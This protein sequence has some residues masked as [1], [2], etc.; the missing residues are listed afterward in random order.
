[1]TLFIHLPTKFQVCQCCSY[2]DARVEPEQE[3]E[4][5]EIKTF[6]GHIIY[7]F[8]NQRYHLSTCVGARVWV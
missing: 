5:K 8:F 2:G 7:P 3:G 6:P 4:G 1:M